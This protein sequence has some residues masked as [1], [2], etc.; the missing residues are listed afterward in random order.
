MKA[1]L[2]DKEALEAIVG[3]ILITGVFAASIFTM[4]VFG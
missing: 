3:G 2:K 1:L 4:I